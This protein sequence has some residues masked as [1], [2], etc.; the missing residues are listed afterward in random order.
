MQTLPKIKAE[1][2]RMAAKIAAPESL[3][4]TYGRSED[5]A[6]PH[7]EVDAHGGYHYVIVE[8]GQER[9]CS[10][11]SDL[12]ELFFNVFHDVTHSL[13]SGYELQNRIE[14][15]DSRRMLF[16]HQIELLSMIFPHWGERERERHEDIL[17]KHPFDDQGSARAILSKS[18]RDQGTSPEAAWQKACEE[19]PLPEGSTKIS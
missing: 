3:L 5:G 7:I 18:Y 8:R 12:D 6:R 14:G 4:P 10:T 1:I 19:F 13:A 15:E 2:D 17:R 11:T 16:R 9:Q